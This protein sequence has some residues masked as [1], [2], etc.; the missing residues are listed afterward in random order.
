MEFHDPS[1]RIFRQ[2]TEAK[3]TVK[4]SPIAK[5]SLQARSGVALGLTTYKAAQVFPRPARTGLVVQSDNLLK[6]LEL[7]WFA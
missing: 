7:V 4:D 5:S 3:P 2:L 1:L 6:Q